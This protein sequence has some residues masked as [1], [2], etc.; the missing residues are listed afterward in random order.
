MLSASED[1]L[2]WPDFEAGRGERGDVGSGLD[3]TSVG[4]SSGLSAVVASFSSV[5]M[6]SVDT[7]LPQD[8][9]KRAKGGSSVPQALQRAM[10][11]N[12]SNRECSA[13]VYGNVAKMG[14]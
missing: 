4:I 3:D 11:T 5:V 8:E 9:Q 6:S 12:A 13:A 1:E 7:V 10:E 14:M 2:G